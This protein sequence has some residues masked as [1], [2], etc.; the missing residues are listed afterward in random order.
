MADNAGARQT[1]ERDKEII[2]KNCAP[3]TNCI[4]EINNTYIDIPKDLDVAMLLY[5]LIKYSDSYLETSG[6]SWNTSEIRQIII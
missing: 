3:F 1:D 5:N 2:L 4:S 6:S